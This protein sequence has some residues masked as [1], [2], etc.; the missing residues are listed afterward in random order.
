MATTSTPSKYVTLVSGDGFEFVV[1]REA[2]MISPIIKGMLEPR[3]Q[4][5][6]ARD[7]RCVFQEMRRHN[8][9]LYP[10]KTDAQQGLIGLFCARVLCDFRLHLNRL[11]APIP[12]YCASTAFEA[13]E[14]TFPANSAVVL[15]K[16]VEYF[17]YWYRYRNSEDVP[18][19]DIP[20]EI[21]LEVLAAADYLGLDQ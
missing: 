11:I 14:L 5:A 17:H 19:M 10:D 20:V 15:D 8:A 21:C 1:L 6:E 13:M 4:F 18:D 16:V 12:K 2:T 3:S 7:A 9:E